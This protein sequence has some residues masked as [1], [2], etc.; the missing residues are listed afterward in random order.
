ME[1]LIK[2]VV[3][4]S[5]ESLRGMN[6]EHRKCYFAD[7]FKLKYFMHYTKSHCDLEVLSEIT[8]EKCGCVPFN[9]IRNKTM[10]ICDVSRWPCA[11]A[12][13]NVVLDGNGNTEFSRHCLPLC[14]SIRYDF[15]LRTKRVG[16]NYS[17]E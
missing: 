11:I 6:V 14:D 16:R 9:Y 2:P 7:E 13:S 17:D 4:R 12:Y 8:F 10:N 15:E 5:D 1:V 3:I